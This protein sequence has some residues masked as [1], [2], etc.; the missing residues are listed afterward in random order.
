MDKF[1]IFF[2]IIFS[3]FFSLS[4]FEDAMGQTTPANAENRASNLISLDVKNINLE[5]ALRL[6]AD[7]SG[8]NIVTSKN[9]RGTITVK[10]KNVPVEDALRA[11]L[12]VNNCKYIKEGNIIK[13]YTYQDLQQEER[14]TKLKT[15]VY[16]LKFAKASDLKPLLLAIKSARGKIEV[17]SKVNQIIVSDIPDVI[18]QIE[19]LIKEVDKE[20]RLRVFE[21]SY[22]D[23]GEIQTKLTQF[24]PKAEGEVMVDTRTN[25]IIVKAPPA[26][27]KEV[28]LLIKKWDR[29]NKQVQIEARILEVTLDDSFKLGINWNYVTPETVGKREPSTSDLTGDFSIDLA[30]GGIFKVGTL[31]ADDYT[32][33]LEMLATQTNTEILSSPK[34]TVLDGQEASILIGSSEP[35]VVTSQ[36]PVTGFV[37]EQTNFLD[38]GIKLI[39]TPKI[40]QDNHITMKIHPEV[41]TARRVAEADNALAVDTTEADTTLTVK[42][43]ETVVLGGL[44]KQEKTKTVKKIPLL[45]DIPLLGLAFR[46]QDEETVKKELMVFITPYVLSA[47]GKVIKEGEEQRIEKLI[48]DTIYEIKKRRQYKKESTLEQD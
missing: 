26:V 2:I 27:Q 8:L 34:I 17:N 6:I 37:T 21:L 30:E 31:S 24:I 9:V 40:G 22:A 36:D 35:Y 5:D 44:M 7:Q 47:E 42:N 11:I 3:V 48:R 12:E 43:G 16:S 1:K 4:F 39:V 28:E 14:F 29:Q 45:G 46:S 33:T 23:A 41:S 18:E 25:S 10:L 38:V 15:K 32:A 13:V 19:G 20:T